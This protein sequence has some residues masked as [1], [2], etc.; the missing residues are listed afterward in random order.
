MGCSDYF[1]GFCIWRDSPPHTSQENN[2]K[3]N[4]LTLGFVL[5]LC[6]VFANAITAQKFGHI[7]SQQLLLDSPEVK[8]ADTQLE[9]Y[10]ASLLEKGK[11]MVADFETE[12]NKYMADV[13]GNTLSPVERQSRE[14][15]LSEKQ[16]AIQKYEVEVQQKLG[17]KR[18]ELYQPIIAKI[19]AAIDAVGKEGS[20]T[21]IFDTATGAL[22]HAV[23]SEDLIDQVKAR[24]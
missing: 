1:C 5:G 12:Y 18:E 17:M 3:L 19:N 24:L 9:T 21:M 16:Q 2:M 7:N 22:L 4:K 11:Q 8:T 20:Y 23:D 14:G 10:Q 13:N 15:A 6:L